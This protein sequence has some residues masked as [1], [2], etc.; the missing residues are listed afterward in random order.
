MGHPGKFKTLAL[1]QQ[2]YWWPGMSR[3][4]NNYVAGCA[5]CQQMKINTH[6]TLPP[7]HPIPANKNALPFQTVSMDFITDLPPSEGFDSIFV[8]VDH[9]VTKGIVLIPCTKNIDASQ[10]AKLYHDHVFQRF[11]LPKQ[12][13]SDRGPQFSSQFFQQLCTKLGIKSKLSTAYHPQ[14]D[15]QTE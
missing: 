6:P 5:L 9:N 8:I 4:S 13:I 12:I 14:S 11:G 10:T 1:L 15:G 7:L 3:F 2:Q